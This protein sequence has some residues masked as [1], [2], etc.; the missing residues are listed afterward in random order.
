MECDSVHSKIDSQLNDSIINVPSDYVPL[1]QCARKKT[2]KYKV[3]VLDYT[4]FRNYKA[5]CLLKSIKPNKATGPPYV[6]GIRQLKYTQE[7]EIFLKL[8]YSEE[9][10]KLL[11]ERRC[12][13]KSA[14]PPRLYK[15][16]LPLSYIK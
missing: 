9:C 3:K 13:K 11:H 1:I 10:W 4:F 15:T 16:E 5:V 7:G 6:E 2:D 12:S 14:D 8:G